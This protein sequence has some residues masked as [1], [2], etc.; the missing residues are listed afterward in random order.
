MI[1]SL[2][3][4]LVLS[5]ATYTRSRVEP[6]DPRSLC[7][8]WPENTAIELRQNE[9]GNP[10]TGGREF[11]AFNNAI[12]T[13]QAR[14]N[15]CAS[16]SLRDGARTTSRKTEFNTSGANENVVVYRMKRCAKTCADGDELCVKVDASSPCW[17]EDQDNC[18]SV[19]DCW[20]H[21]SS[22]IA[23]TTTS[24]Y[25]S[26]ARVLDADI[27]FNWPN[28]YFTAT[29]TE[30]PCPGGTTSQ[31]C[32]V[33]DVENT[34]THEL[35]HLLGLA[36]FSNANSTMFASAAVGETK[37]RTLD[38]GSADFVCDAYPVG[39][40]ARQ[41]VIPV[42]DATLGKQLKGCSVAGGDVLLA[43]GLLL[44]RRRARA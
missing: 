11:T 32:V 37:K 42:V 34:A 9:R 10:E 18:G 41:C 38:Q 27:E 43:L 28:F 25:P 3:L 39:Q 35:G 36:H 29:S 21:A 30:L 6:S 14:L 8:Y 22:A 17:G 16:L 1:V 40:P 12:T 7:L 2:S 44:G 15:Q 23:I 31:S 19:F 26:N 5:Q 4:A 20:Q 13:W 24:Y 33:T